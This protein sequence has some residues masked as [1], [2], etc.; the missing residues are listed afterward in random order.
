MPLSALSVLWCLL[1]F[2]LSLEGGVSALRRPPVQSLALSSFA[3][4]ETQNECVLSVDL[5]LSILADRPGLGVVHSLIPMENVKTVVYSRMDP[6][7]RPGIVS[8]HSQSSP[9][10]SPPRQEAN[11]VYPHCSLNSPHRRGRN[12]FWTQSALRGSDGQ[13][14]HNDA[15]RTFPSLQSLT[16]ADDRL[17]PKAVSPMISLL[18]GRQHFT[19]SGRMGRG[20]RWRGLRIS[21]SVLRLLRPLSLSTR[22]ISLFRRSIYFVLLRSTSPVCRS[23]QEVSRLSVAFRPGGTERDLQWTA[24]CQSPSPVYPRLPSSR[25]DI[26]LLLFFTA[27]TSARPRTEN[28]S[29]RRGRYPTDSARPSRPSSTFLGAG[30]ARTSGRAA[31]TLTSRTPTVPAMTGST[32][33]IQSASC[34]SSVWTDVL[35]R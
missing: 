9:P 25:T 26:S 34:V 10:S 32:A 8:N 18:T 24:W 33:M 15:V 6:I 2:G 11:L 22:L 31:T 28:P 29:L 1:L 35:S 19:I 23:F 14:V 30:L 12:G 4:N 7:V 13:S 21:R 16:L 20:R 17:F 27:G 5:S 3:M